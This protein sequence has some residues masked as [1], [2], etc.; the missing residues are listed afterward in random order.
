MRIDVL[1]LF[2]GMFEGPLTES[3]LK[4][5]QEKGLLTINMVNIRDYTIDKHHIADDYP[6][7]GGVGMV[8]KPEPVF[9][10][11]DDLIERN[12]RPGKV[13]LLCP[14]GRPLTQA[15]IRSLAEE[16]HLVLI[17]GH[18]EGIDERVRENLV[19]DEIS[20]GDFILTG[21]E[22]PAM[23]I[24][25]A[26]SRLLPGVLGE[27]E[28]AVDE[29]FEG[30]LLEYPQY[31]RPREFRG[32]KVPDILLSGDHEKIRQWRRQ[33]SLLRTLRRRPD[34]LKEEDLSPED[35]ALLQKEFV[36]DPKQ[37]KD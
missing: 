4:R 21:G 12:G 24:I 30:G 28:S 31:T 29:S 1:T 32:L 23:V 14:Q 9:R 25:D 10:A 13:I 36:V 18:Y 26:V 6:F 5:A 37:I 3:I 27:A 8:M 15:I 35:K 16:R 11:M 33:Q 2:P 19:T 17:C 22:L 7:G 20:L 34:L